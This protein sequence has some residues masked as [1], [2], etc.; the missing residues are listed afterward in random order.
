VQIENTLPHFHPL[1]ARWFKDRVGRPT[2]LQEEAWPKIAAG[3]H[4]LITAPTGSGK[5]LAAFL[6]AL[7]RSF[8]VL[9]DYKNVNLF[10]PRQ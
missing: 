6:W 4:L 1:V 9:V 7:N 3:E 2:D 8:E 10:H 5:T